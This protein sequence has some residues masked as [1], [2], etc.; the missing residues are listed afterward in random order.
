[1]KNIILFFLGF[2][3]IMN[4]AFAQ[5]DENYIIRTRQG[6]EFIGKIIEDHQD[7]IILKTETYGDLRIATAD[8]VSRKLAKPEQFKDGVYWDENPQSTRYFWTPNGYG[9]KEGERYY[10]NIWVLYNQVSYG[11]TNNFSISAGLIPLFFFGG[12][13][14]PLWVVPKVSIPIKEDYI[15]F[16]AGAF[17]GAVTGVGFFGIGFTTL[18][19]GNRDT[20]ASFSLGWGYTGD[21]FANRPIVNFSF[22]KRTGAKGYLISENYLMNMDD[23]SILILSVGGRRMIQKVGLDFA[24]YLP[25]GMGA[26]FAIPLLGITVPFGN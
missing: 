25:L 5:E 20:N 17:M 8:I 7:Y 1:M 4:S 22:M 18:T 23:E 9:L 12:A 3:L 21:E 13:P 16:G 26:F 11:V 2:F 6:N 24:L 10:Q 14:T 19:I 15:N